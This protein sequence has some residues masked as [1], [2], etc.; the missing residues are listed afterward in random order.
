MSM[1]KFAGLL[2]VLTLLITGCDNRTGQASLCANLV[3][4]Q[5]QIA[6]GFTS[7]EFLK[8][9]E[10]TQGIAASDVKIID[11]LSTPSVGF[12]WTIGNYRYNAELEDNKLT[13]LQIMRVGRSGIPARIVT[14]CLGEPEVYRAIHD[15]E[16]HVL[17]GQLTFEMVFFSGV[18]ASGYQF[19]KRVPALPLSIDENFAIDDFLITSPGTAVEILQQS[20]KYRAQDTFNL[21]HPW[22]ENWED[23]KIDNTPEMQRILQD[24]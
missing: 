2:V 13:E 1:K 11:A 23:I 7:Q 19:Y 4:F 14:E 15:V 18:I 8:W 17:G 3:L 12:Q 9:V 20:Y 5:G 16:D 21:I 24:H 10:K 6:E 22:P